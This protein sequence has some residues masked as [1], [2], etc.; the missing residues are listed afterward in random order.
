MHPD[1]LPFIITQLA[2]ALASVTLLGW[3]DVEQYK[4]VHQDILQFIQVIDQNNS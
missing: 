2:S 3:A 1:L 4:N